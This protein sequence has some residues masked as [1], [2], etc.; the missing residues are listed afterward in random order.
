MDGETLHD[1][2][3]R[4]AEALPEARLEY[5][6]GPDWDVFKV[7]GKVFLLVVEVRGERV[8]ILKAAPLDAEALRTAHADITPGYHMNKRHWITLSPGGSIDAAL[9]EELVTDSYRLVVAGLP[10]ARRPALPDELRG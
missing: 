8:A 3:R 1:T 7:G 10:R 5:P 2:A 6:F 9:V 4:R